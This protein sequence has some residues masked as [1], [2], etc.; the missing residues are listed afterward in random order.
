MMTVPS[1]AVVEETF[2]KPGRRVK[3]IIVE[4]S[5]PPG[6]RARVE[7]NRGNTITIEGSARLLFNV[8]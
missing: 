8:V 3:R 1:G 6:E 2:A 5:P 7:F 4:V